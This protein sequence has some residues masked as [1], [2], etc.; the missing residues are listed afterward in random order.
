MGRVLT[1]SVV[2]FPSMRNTLADLRHPLGGV[3]VTIVGEK[4]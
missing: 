2:H 3:T 4:R 1:G